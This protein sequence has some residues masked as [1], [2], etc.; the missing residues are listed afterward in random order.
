MSITGNFLGGQDVLSFANQNGITGLYNGAT[1]VLT[2][3]GSS[4]VANYQTALRSVMYQNTS[5]DPSTAARTVSFIVN[6]GI[7]NSNT[8]T[9]Q[10]SITAI[11]NPPVLFGIEGTSI[12]YIEGDTGIQITNTITASD[13]DNTTF[14]SASISI[15]GNF[16]SGEDVL[17]FTNQNGITEAI[18][19]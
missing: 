7:A 17:S 16:R 19:V 9:R 3:N 6:D 15:I 1:G 10:I 14:A 13:V 18:T 8:L 11:D 4:S 12:N 5:Q 2:L